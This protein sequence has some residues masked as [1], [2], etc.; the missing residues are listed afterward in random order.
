M[1]RFV[2]RI[3]S[4][5]DLNPMG[6]V[7]DYFTDTSFTL[8]ALDE[9]LAPACPSWRGRYRFAYS[10]Y[11]FG[12]EDGKLD[13]EVKDFIEK[14]ESPV[15]VGFG[16]VTLKE[17]RLFMD[18]LAEAASRTGARLIIG[19]G[20]T[21]LGEGYDSEN[22]LTV[23]DHPH[24][25]LFPRMAGAIHHGGCGTTHSVARAGIPQV[26]LPQIADQFYWAR[27]LEDLGCGP[28]SRTPGRVSVKYLAGV[29]EDMR[30]NSGY[31]ESALVVKDALIRDGTPRAA[32]I[33]LSG[34]QFSDENNRKLK[35]KE[36]VP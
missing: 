31:R 26:A 14:G 33:I 34:D 13:P 21:G 10:G 9:T 6:S 27:R 18:M 12:K 1:R 29:L 17:P 5:L 36:R 19:R 4:D 28:S 30:G 25:L 3:R 23:G 16:S 35:Q 7:A 8:L 15:Y 32:D 2:D 20:W 22:I 24:Y 11:C